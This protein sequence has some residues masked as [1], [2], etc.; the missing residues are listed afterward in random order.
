[1]ADA[2]LFIIGTERSGSNLMRVILN[3][4]PRIAVPHPPHFFKY[5]AH[6][7]RRYGDLEDERRFRAL[8]LDMQRLLRV[9]IYPWEIAVDT[10]RVV[11]EANPRDLLGATCAFYDQYL[12][13]T[14]KA[15]WGCKS[16]FMVHHADRVLA[17]DPEARFIWLVRDPRDV[18]VSSRK[19]VF[20]PFDPVRT[21]ALWTAQQAEGLA[22]E[23]RLGAQVVLRLRYEDLLSAPDL[24]LRRVCRFLGEDHADSMTSF[25]ETGAARKGASLSRDWQKT[26]SPIQASNQGKYRE[27]LSDEEIRDVEAIAAATMRRLDYELEYPDVGVAP[28]GLRARV[29][30]RLRDEIWHAQV[31]LRSLRT[32]KNHWR[33]WGRA[34]TMSWL[35]LTTRM[36]R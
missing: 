16:T 32:D 30:H 20:S 35:E 9:H 25:H 13:H 6:L 15:R 14:R 28:T 26:A 7:E 33:R 5:F 27:E 31:E 18:A 10:D 36:P 17:R 19:S 22:L 1:M 12:E 29:V 2:P 11:R 23:E 21:A 8:V 4:H 3:A 24:Q 34:A